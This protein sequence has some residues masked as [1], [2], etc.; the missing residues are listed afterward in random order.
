MCKKTNMSKRL[1]RAGNS[2]AKQ[3]TDGAENAQMG[4]V[5]QDKC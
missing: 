2:N 1:L 5:C 4:E 3:C